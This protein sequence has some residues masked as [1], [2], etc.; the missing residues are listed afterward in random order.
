[1]NKYKISYYNSGG[2]KSKGTLET[3]YTIKKDGKDNR[4]CIFHNDKKIGYE[5]DVE[6][7][8]LA[9]LEW[10]ESIMVYDAELDED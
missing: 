4:L 6:K 5:E 10:H 2:F 1:M 8:F 3:E 7:L 9:Q